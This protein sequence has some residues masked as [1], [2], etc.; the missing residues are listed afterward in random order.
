M[1]EGDDRGNKAGVVELDGAAAAL[2]Y[3]EHKQAVVALTDAC[4]LV[5]H[6]APFA[7][8]RSLNPAERRR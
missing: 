4:T 3:Y 6:G 2:L 1:V 7:Q 8:P 5:V